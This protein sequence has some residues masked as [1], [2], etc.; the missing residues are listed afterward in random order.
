MGEAALADDYKPRVDVRT[1]S[2]RKTLS[3]SDNGLGMTEEE[4]DKYINQIAFS[5]A[6]DF[7]SKYKDKADQD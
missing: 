4:V 1:S 6:A 5:G 3:V 7:M 2:N